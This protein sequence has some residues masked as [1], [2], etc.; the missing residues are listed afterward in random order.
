MLVKYLSVFGLSMLKFFAGPV[1]GLAVGLKMWETMLLTIGGMMASVTILSFLGIELRHKLVA[2]FAGKKKKFSPRSRRIVRIWKRFGLQG[3][4][5]LTPLILSPLGG[6]IIAIG[7]G[8]TPK[9]IILFMLTSA[10]FWG[11]IMTYIVYQLHGLD[12]FG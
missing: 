5:F 7:F 9:R 11:I 1:T 12:I 3:V 4:A 10:I 6:T 8:E 2:R